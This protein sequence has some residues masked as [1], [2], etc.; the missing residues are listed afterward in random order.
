[1][2]E[3]ILEKGDPTC[4]LTLSSPEIETKILFALAY[5]VQRRQRPEQDNENPLA[6]TEIVRIE[7]LIV[8][9]YPNKRMTLGVKKLKRKD[10]KNRNLIR[11]LHFSAF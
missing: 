5:L 7:L 3:N 1:M 4:T 10:R 6:V 2:K 9:F 8:S 11:S